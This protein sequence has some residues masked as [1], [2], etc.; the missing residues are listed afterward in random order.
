MNDQNRYEEVPQ[1]ENKFLKALKGLG[2]YFKFVFIDFI[3]SFKYNNMKLA[4]IIFALPGILLGFFMFAHVPTIRKVTVA[5]DQVI[6]DSSARINT[7]LDSETATDSDFLLTIDKYNGYENIAMKL[8][9]Y[10]QLKE[11]D[12]P[13]FV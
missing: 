13:S 4:A 6:A 8:V 9:S 5:Y 10:D 7:T 11:E 1:K 2:N 3:N 12:M